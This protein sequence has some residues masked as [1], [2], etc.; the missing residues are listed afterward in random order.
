M[1]GQK[2]YFKFFNEKRITKYFINISLGKNYLFLIIL[3]KL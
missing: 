2:K 3:T 1:N